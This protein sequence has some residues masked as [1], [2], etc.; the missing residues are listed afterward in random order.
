VNSPDLPRSGLPGPRLVRAGLSGSVSDRASSVGTAGP[1]S[2][3]SLFTGGSACPTPTDW[4][5]E[6]TRHP[7]VRAFFR[8]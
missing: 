3:G 4:T 6:H 7:M 2:A 5:L 1:D 8:A